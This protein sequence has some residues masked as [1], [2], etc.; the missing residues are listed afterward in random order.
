MESKVVIREFRSGD[1]IAERYELRD[2]VG[3]GGMGAVWRARHVQLENDVA[4]KLMSPL[5]AAQ[6]EALQR[7]LREARAAARLTSQHV[8]KVFDYGVDAGTP[9]I[10]MELLSGESLACGSAWTAKAR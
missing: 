7:F 10:A 5:I 4:L 3:E 9:F 6:P 8:V 2:L 1:V